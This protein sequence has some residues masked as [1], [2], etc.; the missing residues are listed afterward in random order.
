[1]KYKQPNISEL[2]SSRELLGSTIKAMVAAGVILVTMIMPAEYGIDPT[3]VGGVLG[4]TRMGEIKMQLA[5]EAEQAE[6]AA[7]LPTPSVASSTTASTSDATDEADQDSESVANTDSMTLTLAPDASAEIKLEMSEGSSVDFE[8]TTQG[9]NLNFDT[10]GDGY[11]GTEYKYD[12]GLDTPGQD[13]VLTAQ[14]DGFHGWFFRNRED[15]DVVLTVEA[16]G[17][18]IQMIEL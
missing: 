12:K 4:L 17:D 13:G 1:M 14:G 11:D 15:T 9:G 2:P 18:F 6:E 7:K 5:E 16:T 10:H 3:G 8:W